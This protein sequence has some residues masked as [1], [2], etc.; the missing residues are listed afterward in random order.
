[1]KLGSLLIAASVSL[2]ALGGGLATYIAVTKYQAMGRVSEAQS[3]LQVVRAV[4][5]IPRYLNSER[6]YATN[7]LYAPGAIDAA[8]TAGHEKVRKLT[9]D[10]RDRAMA[11]R[12]TLPGS[13]D[14]RAAI[15]TV[16]EDL[17][18]KLN[19]LRS[20]IDTSLA[21]A[22]DERRQDARK[23]I[24][25]NAALNAV[26]M[27]L[28]ND[29]VRRMALLDGEAYRQAN[30]ASTAWSLRDVGGLNAS[31]HKNMVGFRRPATEAEKLEVAR[32][33]ARNDH[34][35]ASLMELRNDPATN[36]SV[37]AA[38]DTM[39]AAYV[40]RFGKLLEGIRR[41]AET[42][43]YTMDAQRF[44]D[45][46]Q[47]ALG[48]VVTVRDAF[49]A[50]ADEVLAA[51]YAGARNSLIIALAALAVVIGV[52]GAVIVVVRRW[53]TG[54]I[55]ELTERM[56]KLASGDVASAIPSTERGDEIGA[57]ARTVVVFRDSAL[58]KARMEQD[59]E[60][61]RVKAA[62]ERLSA[63]EEAINAE[64]EM[65]SR[66]I[67]AGMARLAEKD[68]TFRLTDDLPEAYAKLQSDFNTAMGELEQ[69]LLSVASSGGAISGSSHEITRSADDLSKRTEQQAASLEETAAALDEITATGK[70]AAEGAEH[71][72]DVVATAKADA[73]KARVVVRSTVEAMGGIEKSAQ[74]ISQI[75]GVIDEIAF[76]TN[77]LALN[78]GVEAARAGDAG[79]GF[80]VVASEVRALA[81]RSAEAAK[82]IK[83]LISTSTTQVAE[84]VDLV[85]AT[86]TALERIL[87]QVNEINGVVVDIAAGAKEQA[88]GLQE[89][90]TAIN[91]MDQTTQ[92]NAAMVEET[93]AASHALAQEAAQLSDMIALFRLSGAG[94]SSH[95]APVRSVPRAAARPAAK[96]APARTTSAAQ[97]KPDP[98][99]QSDWED[100]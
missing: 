63:Q 52:S 57:M 60:A 67:G 42:G 70:K 19:A 18:A 80:A 84:G 78:A 68:L 9:S 53:V 99:A 71:A 48:T 75:I 4:S 13:L 89:V 21:R 98:V 44:Y 91:Q 73:E 62:R 61:A 86:G 28:I 88:T 97:R 11:V 83:G 79:R 92:Q 12:N 76:Q 85:A 36:P 31:L 2:S 82:E 81:Q 26:A 54:P 56:T 77:L 24:A 3:R 43:N 87:E 46:S 20:E 14:D 32:T 41:E 47:P 5:D 39:H 72:R 90:N 27:K 8:G 100:F 66:S 51:A 74:Q 55:V 35:H 6:G 40:D 1:M 15:V 49:Y 29:Q 17:N 59:A 58:E 45:E 37:K 7:L 94:G 25:G 64:R 93:T 69:A 10:A 16:I 96:T 95:A 65:V 34:I 23:I 38:L 22:P 30:F 33:Q 50:N